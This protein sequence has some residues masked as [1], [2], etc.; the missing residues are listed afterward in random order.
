[1]N[2]LLLTGGVSN[3]RDVSLRS[4]QAIHDALLGAGHKVKLADPADDGFDLAT[5]TQDIDVV[6][7]ALH[8]EGGEDGIL[9][10]QLEDLGIQFVGSGSVASVLCWR[11]LQYKELLQANQLPA[12]EG[13]IITAKDLRDDSSTSYHAKYL[14]RPFVLKPDQGGSSLDTLIIRTPTTADL[15]KAYDLLVNHYPTGM[16]YE[17]LIDGI[18]ITVGI[19]NQEPLPIV[20]IIPPQGLEFDYDNKY[21][22]KTQELCPPKHI[23]E[24]LQIIAQELALKIHNLANC[25]G[26]SRTDMMVDRHQQ[27]HV[28]E[29]NTM[30][31][32]TTTKL[33]TKIVRQAGYTKTEMIN[34]LLT[35]ATQ[36]TTLRLRFR[37]LFSFGLQPSL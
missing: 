16:L 27:L 32:M 5:L 31:G 22:G 7:P 17:P 9:Q 23:G 1:M 24:D 28:L 26:L 14:Q 6:F 18:E 10:K 8:G 13:V 15:D 21:N 37:E 4:G 25:S 20:E 2:V 3:E 35:T 29:T 33:L 36:Q 12:S 30:P 19:L 11:K 34:Q